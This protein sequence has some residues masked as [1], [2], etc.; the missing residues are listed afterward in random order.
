[1]EFCLNFQQN[2]N[3]MLSLL[4]W[5][6]EHTKPISQTKFLKK[7]IWLCPGRKLIEVL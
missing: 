5:K 4:E 2:F 7:L 3:A 1:M 6:K